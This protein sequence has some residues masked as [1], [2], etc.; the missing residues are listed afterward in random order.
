MSFTTNVICLLLCLYGFAK[1]LYIR[2]AVTDPARLW[3]NGRVPY[4]FHSGIDAYRKVHL[5]AG[6]KQ[7]MLSTYADGNPCITFVPR[8]NEADY[9]LFQFVDSGVPNSKIGR[10]G[11]EQTVSIKRTVTQS[12]IAQALMFL[13]GVFP[14]VSRPDRDNFL[15]VNT[16]NIDPANMKNFLVRN[17]TDTFFQPFDYETVAMYNPYFEAI[18]KSIPTITTKYPG[19]TI[20]QGISLSNGDI[21]LLQHAYKCPLDASHRV[22][23]LGPLLFECHFHEDICQLTQDATD[24][25]DWQLQSGSTTPG[26]GPYADHSSGTGNYAVAQA[27]GHSSQIAKLAFPTLPAGTY[28]VVVWIHAFGPDVGQLRVIQT[29]SDGDKTIFGVSAQPVNQWYHGSGTVISPNSPVTINIE[30]F[31]GSGTQGDIALDD[32][33]IYNGKCID[34]Y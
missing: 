2:N 17:S 4:V 1:A 32:V 7:V 22:D 30:A 24:N 21:N 23:I 33:Y 27:A 31:M 34:W 5:L 13:L 16:A 25:F 12:N 8:T 26:T 3:P 11:G 6:M 9:V 19:Y 15:N 14:E 18:N 10:A 29:N 28:C 20:G